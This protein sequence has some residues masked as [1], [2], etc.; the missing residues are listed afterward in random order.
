MT[1]ARKHTRTALP[2]TARGAR[3]YCLRFAAASVRCAMIAGPGGLRRRTDVSN[4][5]AWLRQ[6]RGYTGGEK[7]P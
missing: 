5:R 3:A 4:A 6:A 1:T 7:L 2:T